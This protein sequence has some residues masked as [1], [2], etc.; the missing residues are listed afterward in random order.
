MRATD[1]LALKIA[2]VSQDEKNAFNHTRFSIFNYKKRFRMNPE[3]KEG[4]LNGIRAILLYRTYNVDFD[5][6]GEFS[7]RST[8]GSDFS[9]SLLKS[10]LHQSFR[11]SIYTNLHFHFFGGL[12]FGEL[13]PQKWFDFG[14][15]TFLNYY[16]NVR[17]VDYKA[18]TGDRMLSAIVE[19]SITGTALYDRGI[20]LGILKALKLTCWSSVGWSSLSEKNKRFVAALNTS[21]STTDGV[22]NEMGIGI[23][24]RLNIVRI[25]FIRNTISKNKLLLSFNI[26]R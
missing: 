14:G 6:T 2:A 9:Y 10:Y 7:N 16:G 8:L 23:G 15:K 24:D 12:S 1:N 26:L 3:I 25:D 11:P 5:L 22:Y 13:P 17:G 20:K 21:L 18:F 19:Y 4:R